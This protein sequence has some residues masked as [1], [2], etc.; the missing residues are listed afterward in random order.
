MLDIANISN[1]TQNNPTLD[2]NLQDRLWIDNH[3]AQF[4]ELIR[5]NYAKSIQDFATVMLE[6]IAEFSQAYSGVFYLL[7]NSNQVLQA[8]AGYACDWNNVQHQTFKFGQGLV[9]QSAELQKIIFFENLPA[10]SIHL[11]TSTIFKIS[12]AGIFVF[13]LCFNGKL[14]GVIEL[15]FVR[16]IELRQRQVLE[17]VSRN[18]AIMLESMLNNALTQKLLR[19]SQEQTESLRS[20]EEELRQ[21]MEE[22]SA[23]QEEMYKQQVLLNAQ[24]TAIDNSLIAKVEFTPNGIIESANPA[25]CQ[26]M[27]Y[28]LD[29]IVGK[30]H[31]IFVSPEYAQ[32]VDYQMFWADLKAGKTISGEYQRVNKNQ[33]IIWI[34]GSYVAI[35]NKS[36][37]VEKV[38]KLAIDISKSKKEIQIGKVQIDTANKQ[39]KKQ[40]NDLQQLQR[41]TEARMRVFNLTTILS[42]SD[43][44]GNITFVN[45]KLCE[46][47]QYTREELIGK[48][49]NILR[50]PDMPQE[51]FKIFWQTIQAGQVFKGII[52]NRKK[53]GTHYWVDAVVSPV[54]DEKNQPCKYIGARYLIENEALAQAAFKKMLKDWKIKV[55]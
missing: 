12:A 15:V 23:T 47:S 38:L 4:D 8:T 2:Y 25:F 37:E 27:Q 6:Q 51:V 53:D 50:H 31:R 54:L 24:L 28:S 35:Q 14:Y 52:K 44:Y 42:E 3:I 41:D 40:L 22:L 13:P 29:E 20:Q 33:E 34:S 10:Q 16:A 55:K 48:P 46:V 32:S 11:N 18:I 7:D 5:H 1:I 26:L 30:H 39:L 17:R 43:T 45:D 49:H 19:D 9:G 36:G 21:N